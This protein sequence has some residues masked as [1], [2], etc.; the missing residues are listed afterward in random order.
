M[1]MQHGKGKALLLLMA[2]ACGCAF[3]LNRN[4]IEL[5]TFTKVQERHSPEVVTVIIPLEE[6]KMRNREK[7]INQLL[8]ENVAADD[9]RLIQVIRNYFIDPPS[10]KQPKNSQGVVRTPQATAVE[11]ILNRKV[12]WSEESNAY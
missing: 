4:N 10:K 3:M 5:T 9:K 12:S 6:I 7:A 8:K 1:T 2:L 11:A